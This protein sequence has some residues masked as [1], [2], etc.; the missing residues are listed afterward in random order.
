MSGNTLPPS[1]RNSPRAESAAAFARAPRRRAWVLAGLLCLIAAVSFGLSLRGRL[2]DLRAPAGSSSHAALAAPR[3]VFTL[4]PKAAAAPRWTRLRHPL[5]FAP[6]RGQTDSRAQFVARG[7]GYVMFFTRDSALIRTAQ[8]ASAAGERSASSRYQVLALRLL[9][10]NSV[11]PTGEVASASRASYFFA[12]RSVVNV[13]QYRRLLYSRPY[14]GVDLVYYGRDGQLE[15]DFNA[16]PGA[17]P[18]AIRFAVEGARPRLTPA[19]DLRL[20]VGA[21]TFYLRRPV[22]YQMIA[23]ERRAVSAAYRLAGDQV[24]F[25]LG[26]YDHS[27]E[28]VIDP[29][30]SFST[31]IGGTG[32]DAATAVAADSKGD[33]YVAGSTQSSDFPF[34]TGAFQTA[35]AGDY[36]VFVAA[37]DPTGKQLFATYLGGSGDDEATGVAVDA[38]NDV[39]VTGFTSSTNFPTTTGA[40]ATANAGGY[41]AFVTKVAAGGASLAYSTYLGGAKDDRAQGIA[42]DANGN[43]YVTGSTSSANYPTSA[44]AP[45]TAL[46]GRVNSFVTEIEPNG[47]GVADLGFSTYLGGSAQDSGNAIALSTTGNIYVAGTTSSPNFPV[48]PAALQSTFGSQNGSGNDA[49]VAKIDRSGALDYATYLGGS[50]D[51]EG[52]GIAVNAAGNAFVA[53]FTQ[54]TNFPSVSGSYRTQLSAGTDVFVAELSTSGA[55]LDYSTYM[56]GSATDQAAG[57]AL[58][59]QGNA[60]VTGFTTSTDFP[61][62]ATAIQSSIGGTADAFLFKLDP[63]GANLLYSTYLGG[64]LLDQGTAVTVDPLGDVFVA[65]L[66]NSGNFPTSSNAFQTASKGGQDGFL[67]K[68]TSTP[69]GAFAPSPLSFPTQAFG[70]TSVAETVVLTNAGE[71]PLIIPQKGL[72]FTGPFAIPSGTPDTC[73]AN[74]GSPGAGSNSAAAG[75]LAPGASCSIPVVFSPTGSASSTSPTAAATGALTVTDNAPGGSQSLTLTGTAGSFSLSVNPTTFT[76]SAGSSASFALTITP[77]NDYTQVINLTCT[78]APTG[79]TCTPTPTSVTMNGSSS[80]TAA[81]TVTT[82]SGSLMPPAPWSLPTGPWRW[83]LLAALAALL[84][85]LAWLSRRP[86]LR[87]RARLALLGVAGL[88]LL[89]LIA[90]GCGGSSTTPATPAGTYS[91]NLIGTDAKGVAQQTT[92]SLTVNQ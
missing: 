8:R 18:A 25:A 89:A 14:A 28:L 78:G 62:T 26:R 33:S 31:Y 49:F 40:Y 3:A 74:A 75:T 43:A 15:Y 35:A 71:L 57:I 27:S 44:G 30:L 51:D 61:V 38:G 80:Q 55:A 81:F 84:A 70:T 42:L 45:Q 69:L 7:A 21:Q 5:L 52:T 47:K 36:D 50:A 56:G 19:G 41:D 6:N 39:Y 86:A 37:F 65:G 59:A 16:A 29:V 48:T 72:N 87:G 77:A 12:H 63:I 54:S 90:V 32:L 66:T 24:A 79:A 67:V 58:D 60:Y 46:A 10:A 22:A 17:D 85:A 92:V 76:V 20:Q 83:G 34:T 4:A 23:G 64:S 82:S 53:G 1:F 68:M 11:T 88:M 91:I 9:G 2:R 73:G 13:P